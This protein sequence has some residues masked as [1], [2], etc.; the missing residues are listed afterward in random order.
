MPSFIFI[1]RCR[2]LF[3]IPTEGVECKL[4]ILM[5]IG[6]RGLGL[7]LES[8]SKVFEFFAFGYNKRKPIAE[9]RFELL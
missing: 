2:L 1:C 5:Y 6:A 7:S 8:F 9:N 4:L 3:L